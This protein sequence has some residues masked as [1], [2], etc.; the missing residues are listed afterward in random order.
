MAG[1]NGRG[2]AGRRGAGVLSGIVAIAFWVLLFTVLGNVLQGLPEVWRWVVGG[3]LAA[4]L[5]IV[6]YFLFVGALLLYFA[7]KGKRID[8]K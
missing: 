6:A 5:P 2:R 8:Y 7:I 3:L 4:A 1:F